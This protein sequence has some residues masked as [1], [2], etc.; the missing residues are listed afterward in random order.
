MQELIPPPR[1]KYL[2][3][4]MLLWLSFAVNAQIRTAYSSSFNS[5]DD[6]VEMI[7][8]EGVEFSNV[9]YHGNEYSMGLFNGTFNRGFDSGL[10]LCTGGI[11][12]VIPGNDVRS[13]R[14]PG[15]ES[16]LSKQ[17]ELIGAKTFNLFN[18]ITLEFDFIP[19]SNQ[20]QFDY[21]FASNEYG[22]FTCSRYNDIFGFFLSGPGID[23]PFENKAKNIALVPNPD[24]STLFTNSPVIINT[25]NSGRPSSFDA[26]LCDSIDVNWRSYSKFYVDNSAMTSISFLGHTT[27][28][29]SIANL[30]PCK[31][32]HIKIA[33]ADCGDGLLN[34][35]VFLKK[36]S[37]NS[38]A[39]INY[40]IKSNMFDVFETP[41]EN[42]KHLY[43][44]CGNASI[45]FKR[46]DSISGSL[47]RKILV[48]GAA[49]NKLDF[50]LTN[51]TNGVVTIPEE[52]SISTVMISVLNDSIKE[53]VEEFTLKI[54]PSIDNCFEIS[55]DSITFKIYDQP[56]LFINTLEDTLLECSGDS[57]NLWANAKGGMSGLLAS[58]ESY[59]GYEYQWLGEEESGSIQTVS[60]HEPKTYYVRVSDLCNQNVLDSTFIDV[61]PARE[62]RLT[63][64]R[65]TIC[66]DHKDVLC[67]NILSGSGNYTYKWPTGY[68]D[69]CTRVYPGLYPVVVQDKC[70]HVDTA[71]AQLVID[72]IPDPNFVISKVISDSLGVRLINLTPKLKDLLYSWDFGDSNASEDHQPSTHYFDDAGAYF[73]RLNVNNITNSCDK[74]SGKWVRVAPSYQFYAPQSF[75]PNGDGLNDTFNPYMIGHQD[76][77][78]FIYDRWGRQVFYSNQLDVV[79]DGRAGSKHLKSGIY[80][81][82]IY[83]SEFAT[84]LRFQESGTINLFR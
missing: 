10:V 51:I 69:S 8:G 44:G 73:I 46:P 7:L 43:E 61:L 67:V 84:G 45:T 56:D 57:V 20:L 16:D 23:G 59:S 62:L 27:P 71:Y 50:N 74:E 34:S 13:Y 36:N 42:P 78:L 60:V 55:Y 66:T 48:S 72:S 26:S 64:E 35:A 63:S 29:A 82:M 37:F 70:G 41:W 22:S 38:S 68:L 83:A 25:I 65:K 49:T 24:D 77:E 76:Y 32:Y 40:T 12:S 3:P 28:I 9:I 11:S 79:W 75:T 21:I 54:Y 14:I 52:D 15:V 33:L 19:K 47:A 58:S 1:M 80:V 39:K 81:Y 31:T 4:Q 6:I 18:V 17:L 53:G 5:P 2:I 30:I